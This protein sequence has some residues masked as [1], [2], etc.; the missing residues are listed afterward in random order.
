[1]SGAIGIAV[2]GTAASPRKATAGA[3]NTF[4]ISVP[5]VGR[6]RTPSVAVII[7]RPLN[8]LAVHQN[9]RVNEHVPCVAHRR[10][11][12]GSR[13]TQRNGRRVR[14]SPKCETISRR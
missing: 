9:Y 2:A 8:V 5:L 14:R 4:L 1:M 13:L 6:A 10:G 7:E 3:I 11:R 12:E